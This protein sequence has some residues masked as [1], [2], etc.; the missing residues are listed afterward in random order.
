MNLD[1]PD[2]FLSTLNK[3]MPWVNSKAF[4]PDQFYRIF[5]DSLGLERGELKE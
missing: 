4:Y 1:V 2:D 3:C 5:P